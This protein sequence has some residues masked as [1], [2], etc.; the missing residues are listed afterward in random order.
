MCPRVRKTCLIYDYSLMLHMVPLP[1]LVETAPTLLSSSVACSF[2][3]SLALKMP[4]S[5][6]KNEEKS[7]SHLHIYNVMYFLFYFNWKTHQT[8]LPPRNIFYPNFY[9]LFLFFMH[10]PPRQ[11]ARAPTRKNSFPVLTFYG[12]VCCLEMRKMFTAH[13][14]SGSAFPKAVSVSFIFFIKRSRKFSDS[15]KQSQLRW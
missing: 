4:G 2:V 1:A 11:P 14:N 7:C 13:D 3:R 9:L 5:P 10:Q 15:L 8:I 12:C 6:E